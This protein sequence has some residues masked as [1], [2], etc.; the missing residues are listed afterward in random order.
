[1]AASRTGL[2]RPSLL[3]RPF[4]LLLIIAGLAVLQASPRTAVLACSTVEA[5][6]TLVAARGKAAGAPVTRETGAKPV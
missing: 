2:I 5:S 6:T 1:M 3:V 4:V